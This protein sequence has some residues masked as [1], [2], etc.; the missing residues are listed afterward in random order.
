MSDAHKVWS[1][2]GIW[3]ETLQGYNSSK[4]R[5]H[6]IEPKGPDI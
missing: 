6:E 3:K 4:A 5:G 2:E 1:M